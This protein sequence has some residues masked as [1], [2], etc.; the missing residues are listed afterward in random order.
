MSGALLGLVA[1]GNQ[2]VYLTKDPNVTF[3]KSAFKRYSMFQKE[4]VA[5]S[6]NGN[7]AFGRK[8][9]VP[10]V[11]SGDLASRCYVEM[12]LPEL[13]APDNMHIAYCKYVGLALLESV[14]FLIGGAKV[15]KHYSTWLIIMHELYT[16]PGKEKN[17]DIMIGNVDLLTTPKP[18]IPEYKVRVPLQFFFNRFYKQALPLVA[19]QYN[20]CQFDIQFKR[21]EDLYTIYDVSGPTPVPTSKTLPIAPILGAVNVWCEYIF[22]E[23]EERDAIVADVV[24]VVFEQTQFNSPE[25]YTGPKL[26]S[27]LAFNHPVSELFFMIQLNT[28]VDNGANR[29]ADF[30]M[31]G[32]DAAKAYNGAQPLKSATLMLNGNDRFAAQDAMYF[33]NQVPYECH[34]RSPAAGIYCYSFANNPEDAQPSG[35]LNFSRIDS[36]ALAIE[37][38]TGNQ[39]YNLLVF[40]KNYNVLRYKN[41]QAGVSFSS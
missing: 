38:N 7:P 20:P 29:W 3:F 18:V 37:T 27:R 39:P 22:L 34:S 41:G 5:L 30:T 28:N 16:K 33:N 12:V 19:L 13:V 21:A 17:A 36:A 14:E 2:D 4:V 6:A 26:K 8:I 40:C 35:T 10:I 9:T 31:S 23:D 15:D 32:N 1:Y 25:A 11:R 24:D